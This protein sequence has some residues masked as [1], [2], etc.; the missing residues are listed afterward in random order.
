MIFKMLS[1]DSTTGKAE[2]T[3]IKAYVYD[4]LEENG[5]IPRS[6]WRRQWQKQKRRDANS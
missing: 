3:A 1:T 2:V 6:E 5:T 4:A